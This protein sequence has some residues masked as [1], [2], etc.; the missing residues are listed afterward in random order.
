MFYNREP[1]P[2]YGFSWGVSR[3]R[4]WPP[5]SFRHSIFRTASRVETRF[6]GVIAYKRGSPHDTEW[7]YCAPLAKATHTQNPHLFGMLLES[8]IRQ[9]LCQPASCSSGCS[10]GSTEVLPR[11]G[12]HPRPPAAALFVASSCPSPSVEPAGPVYRRS[13]S[14]RQDLRESDCR[15]STLY[16]FLNSTASTVT[17]RVASGLPHCQCHWYCH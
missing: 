14:E 4:A 8:C 11:G 12:C 6:L 10:E 17:E 3:L 13:E 1:H 9:L 5:P 16:I 15:R 7:K 2:K